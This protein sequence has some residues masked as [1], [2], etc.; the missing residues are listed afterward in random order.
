[1]PDPPVSSLQKILEGVAIKLIVVALLSV[2]TAAVT[3]YSAHSAYLSGKPFY[4]VAPYV[5]GVVCLCFITLYYSWL[6]IERLQ[7]YLTANRLKWLSDIAEADCVRVDKAVCVYDCELFSQQLS[8][9][10]PY[11]EIEL[12]LFNGSVYQLAIKREVEGFITIGRFSRLDG[13]LANSGRHQLD[14]IEPR[15][16]GA[17]Y[18]TLWLGEK[19]VAMLNEGNSRDKQ[20]FLDQILVTVVGANESDKIVPQLLQLTNK[21]VGFPSRR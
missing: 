6:W 14:L 4:E 7:T 17:L 1:M 21:L 5:V 19:E 2:G 10:S 9:N 12:N 18:L 13:R 3:W 15:A 20:L 11:I 8:G 16:R